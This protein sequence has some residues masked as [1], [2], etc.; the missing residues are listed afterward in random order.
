MTTPVKTTWN[1][2]NHSNCEVTEYV[3]CNCKNDMWTDI[4]NFR[5]H[6]C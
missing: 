4:T 2:I 3:S 5:S 6:S 1:F